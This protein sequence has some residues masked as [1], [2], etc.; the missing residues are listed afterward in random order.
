MW[1]AIIS[2]LLGIV[3]WVWG[4]RQQTEGEAQGKAEQAAVDTGAAASAEGR[5]AKAEA[6]A[7]TTEEEALKRLRD[8]SA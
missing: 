3:K 6:D 4:G 2:F 5:I 7:P 8:G 1:P